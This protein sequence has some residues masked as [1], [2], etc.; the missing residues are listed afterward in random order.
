MIIICPSDQ[1]KSKCGIGIGIG[2]GELSHHCTC[3]LIFRYLKC[4]GGI[5]VGGWCVRGRICIHWIG[6]VGNFQGVG[7][8]VVVIIGIVSIF[9]PV[10]VIVFDHIGHPNSQAFF[11]KSTIPII[12]TEPDFVGVVS[13]GIGGIFKVGSRGEG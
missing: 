3:G 10:S 13:I 5:Q 2:G 11:V 9:N 8:A 12:G 7:K 4:G 6:S 1:C